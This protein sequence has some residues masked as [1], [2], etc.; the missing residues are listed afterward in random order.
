MICNWGEEVCV[1]SVG[2]VFCRAVCL[3]T[4]GCGGFCFG[5]CG[6]S[7]LAYC[8]LIICLLDEFAGLRV[9]VFAC[10]CV[11]VGVCG[12]CVC[13]DARVCTFCFYFVCLFVCL[14][15]CLFVCFWG[16]ECMVLLVQSLF[17]RFWAWL[18]LV[19]FRLWCVVLV[20]RVCWLSFS[21]RLAS[22]LFRNQHR[23]QGTL[24]ALNLNSV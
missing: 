4:C 21:G 7:W 10:V 1:V 2:C 12:V 22:A 20:Y 23:E 13:A 3:L 17:G 9:C 5:M 19:C 16:G 6:T 8:A 18:A 15:V 24:R 14:C 11:C